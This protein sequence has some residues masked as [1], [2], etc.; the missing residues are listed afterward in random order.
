MQRRGGNR[1][2]A[3]ETAGQAND[4]ISAAAG[5]G[6]TKYPLCEAL[7]A[8]CGGEGDTLLRLNQ[9]RSYQEP[10]PVSLCCSDLVRSAK[11]S[12]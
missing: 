12:T 7:K 1:Q 10:F 11:Q 5:E 4:G 9:R 3:G 2:A 8:H 6:D